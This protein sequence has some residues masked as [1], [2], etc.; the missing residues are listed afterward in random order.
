[1]NDPVV[2]LCTCISIIS[3]IISCTV[4]VT[5]ADKQ[6]IK[7]MRALINKIVYKDSTLYNHILNNKLLLLRLCL[8]P[9]MLPI[10]VSLINQLGMGNLRIRL[11]IQSL[12][13][14]IFWVV[15]TINFITLNKK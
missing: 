2:I 11:D 15:L 10:A 8:V 3:I 5:Q 4:L 12:L 7:P 9:L 14:S 13:L 6:D 1:M